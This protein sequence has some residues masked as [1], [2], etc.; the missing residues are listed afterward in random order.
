VKISVP[1]DLAAKPPN[2]G[3][4]PSLN[5]KAQSFLDC[6][7]FCPR[8]AA[9]HCL[10]HQAVID[11]Y[12]GTHPFH[13]PMCKDIIFLCIDHRWIPFRS[14][15]V[16]DNRVVSLNAIMFCRM[17]HRIHEAVPDPEIDKRQDAP[18]GN[19]LNP[20]RPQM[21]RHARAVLKEIREPSRLYDPCERNI[22]HPARDGKRW[23]GIPAQPCFLVLM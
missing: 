23:I 18:V 21:V 8:S 2:A 12:I 16:V 10:P 4:R 14:L 3:L 6:S 11:I 13:L 7:P 9:P 19:D 20:S 1:T 15:P 5:Q 17:V 22:Q